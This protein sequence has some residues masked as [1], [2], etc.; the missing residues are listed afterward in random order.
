MSSTVIEPFRRMYFSIRQRRRPG[1]PGSAG[2]RR[3]CLQPR[4]SDER[5][6]GDVRVQLHPARGGAMQGRRQVQRREGPT[7]AVVRRGERML[8]RRGGGM[9]K[10]LFLNIL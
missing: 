7:L 5:R 1:Q 9:S 3:A 10:C 8:R 2:E 4:V 6:V